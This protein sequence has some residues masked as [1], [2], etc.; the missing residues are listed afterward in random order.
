MCPAL[1]ATP[2]TIACQAPLSMGF[3]RQ[4]YWN[5]LPFPF[6]GNLPDPGIEPKAPSLAGGF[7][8]TFIGPLLWHLVP[9][10]AV[11]LL[12]C[13]KTWKREKFNKCACCEFMLAENQNLL[14]VSLAV[15]TETSFCLLTNTLLI[16]TREMAWL[17]L[18]S[19]ILPFALE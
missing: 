2:W 10:S 5:G 16:R 4:E 18:G 9:N 14:L 7:F 1:F 3:P 12:A 19:G 11:K 8:T 17:C 6:S 15:K 13:R